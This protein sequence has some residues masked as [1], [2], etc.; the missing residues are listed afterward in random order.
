MTQTKMAPKKIKSNFNR[1]YSDQGKINTLTD[2]LVQNLDTFYKIFDTDYRS[3]QTCLLSS[4]FIHGG[5][6]PSALNVYNKADYRTH[7]KCRTHQCEEIFGT[8]IISLIRG[9]LSK[10]KYGW[11]V[12]GDKTASFDETIDFI[13]KTLGLTFDKLDAQKVNISNDDNTNFCRIVQSLD[14]SK[15]KEVGFTKEQYR[16]GGLIFPSPYFIGRNFPAE[17]L[18]SYDVG[19]CLKPNKEMSERAVVPIYNE[20]GNL[21]IGFSGRSIYD[22]C[23]KCN[24]W[25]SPDKSCYFFP[26]WRHSSGFKKENHLYNYWKAKEHILKTGT[27]VIVESPANVWRLEQA[28]VFNSVAIFGTTLSANQKR[29]IDE[30]GALSLVLIM[31]NDK[32]L[33]GQE[34]AKKIQKQCEKMYRTFIINLNDKND[35]AE[36]SANEITND[37]KPL[38]DNI[39]GNL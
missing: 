3:G 9:G 5:D 29:I 16:S 2:I 10:H 20:V 23:D 34:A 18:D 32:N 31:D 22:K 26:K 38:I 19:T 7:F 15:N 37:I 1:K 21:I 12:K 11:Q 28:G 24:H 14:N 13:L 6:N 33:A 27:V 25:H 35:I 36:L 39:R 4:C 30:S 8:S 17:L